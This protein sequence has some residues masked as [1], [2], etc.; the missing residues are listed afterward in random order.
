MPPRALLAALAAGSALVALTGCAGRA[1]TMAVPNALDGL[2]G[3]EPDQPV[4][5]PS[6][7]L[8]DDDGQ[9]YDLVAR[10][11]G[12][13]TLLYFGYTDC[14][15]ECPTAMA[16]IASALRTSTPQV[17]DKTVVVFITTNPKADPPARLKQWLGKYGYGPDVVGLTG[18]QAQVDE[19]QRLAG[20]PV[21]VVGG[22]V[23]T[24]S[25]DPTEHVH[26][27]GTPPHT[28]DRALG[29]AVA[30][31]TDILAYDASDKLRVLYPTSVTPAD[32]R[33][34]LPALTR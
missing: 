30:H 11:H 25:A 1:P 9:P 26:V 24:A 33:A 18:T 5:R 29:Y 12:R 8:T 21:A 17:R 6:I 19:A 7:V 10:T 4:S 14:P 34:D 15:D 23:P 13:A 20:V 32:I 27:A 28:H 31:A 3:T 16:Y 22:P 2:H